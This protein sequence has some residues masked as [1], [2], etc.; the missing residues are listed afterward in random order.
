MGVM[1]LTLPTRTGKERYD[2]ASIFHNAW[3]LDAA[4]PNRWDRSELKRDG[5]VLASHTYALE[6]KYGFRGLVTPQYTRTVDT[7]ITPIGEK[8]TTIIQNNTSILKSLIGTLPRHDYLTSTL[9]PESIAPT[10][11][12]LLGYEQQLEITFR[13]FNFDLKSVLRNIEQ[14]TRNVIVSTGKRLHV[15]AHS[16]LDKY[17]SLSIIQRRSR[18]K[19]SYSALKRIFD[20]CLK[21]NSA[22]ILTASDDSGL[23]HASAILVWDNMYLYYFASARDVERGLGGANSLLI[24]T[25]CEMSVEKGLVFDVDSFSSSSQGVFLSKF[26]FEPCYRFRV[27]QRSARYTAFEAL[28][29]ALKGPFS[30]D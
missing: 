13:N 10:A 23:D 21:Y 22:C 26:G 28:K 27:H 7:T 18:E 12:R 11:F 16:D 8:P 9:P 3:W 6:E 29:Q 1:N 17:I 24:W 25:A 5:V 2:P 14:K 15:S 20:A 19:N 30:T 4:C